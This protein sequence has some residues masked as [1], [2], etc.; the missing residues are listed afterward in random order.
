MIKMFGDSSEDKQHKDA[1]VQRVA[2][3]ES[4]T[5]SLYAQASAPAQTSSTLPVLMSRAERAAYMIQQF[6]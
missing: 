4:I 5:D 6:A 1:I 2:E 3:V